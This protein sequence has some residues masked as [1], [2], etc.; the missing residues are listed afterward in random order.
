MSREWSSKSTSELAN[1]AAKSLPSLHSLPSLNTQITPEG[2]S[3][4][5]NAGGS[6]ADLRNMLD[7]DRTPD[8]SSAHLAEDPDS[9]H[10]PS[11]YPPMPQSILNASQTTDAATSD[12]HS[13]DRHAQY[14][15]L[16][17][18]VPHS[19]STSALPSAIFPSSVGSCPPTATTAESP[20]ITPGLRVPSY[21]YG[22]YVYRDSGS[23]LAGE[24]RPGLQLHSYKVS[25]GQQSS[26]TVSALLS[27]DSNASVNLD[28]QLGPAQV[29]RPPSGDA[30]EPLRIRRQQ[31]PLLRHPHSPVLEESEVQSSSASSARMQTSLLFNTTDPFH[32]INDNETASG[33]HHKESE[34]R[35][36]R[37]VSLLPP[38]NES[39]DST[40]PFRHSF[41]THATAGSNDDS[42][43]PPTPTSA[44]PTSATPFP[45]QRRWAEVIRRIKAADNKAQ[46]TDPTNSNVDRLSVV[47]L[48]STRDNPSPNGSHSHVGNSQGRSNSSLVPPLPQG[49]TSDVL[50]TSASA[51]S[52]TDS[53][54]EFEFMS[55]PKPPT[56]VPRHQGPATPG[57]R[58]PWVKGLTLPMPINTAT[59][60]RST[61][62]PNT[63]TPVSF[64]PVPAVPAP[65]LSLTSPSAP[66]TPPSIPGLHPTF[67]VVK[68]PSRVVVTTH[69]TPVPTV[70]IPEGRD[71]WCTDLRPPT[72]PT[73]H[74]T[75]LPPQNQNH[76]TTSVNGSIATNSKCHLLDQIW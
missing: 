59:S 25:S 73:S 38:A 41:Q 37:P 46:A 10:P 70:A 39:S 14:A 27:S 18:P 6:G 75:S 65:S 69:D 24:S 28:S 31:P 8:G 9:Y 13:S 74:A 21:Y 47:V 58:S 15:T 11:S 23:S 49:S 19:S 40:S 48:L 7:V 64:P 33:D 67:R 60:R 62:E 61:R 34:S 42:S 2:G 51:T 72:S 4:I 30:V 22:S 20:P 32:D 12:S 63:L 36:G 50:L 5:D 43:L 54:A 17:L 53:F 35:E 56:G 3:D 57:T 71:S 52:G 68:T 45:D 76:S 66:S 55:F 16:R 44:T 1:R 29:T 26:R